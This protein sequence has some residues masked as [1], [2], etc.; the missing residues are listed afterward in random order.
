MLRIY[1]HARGIPQ[2]GLNHGEV[3]QVIE[4][5]QARHPGLFLTGNAYR[6]ISMNDCVV[7]AYNLAGRMLGNADAESPASEPN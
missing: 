1:R 5:A 7:E 6:G 4:A 3:L 2:Y